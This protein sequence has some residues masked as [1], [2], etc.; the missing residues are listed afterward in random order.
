MDPWYEMTGPG[1]DEVIK[2]VKSHKH[3]KEIDVE[4][5][6]DLIED[7]RYLFLYHLLFLH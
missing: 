5:Y 1:L 6:N 2:I 3:F 4:K 7:V